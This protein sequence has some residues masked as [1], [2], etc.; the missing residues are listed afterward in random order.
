[1]ATSELVLWSAAL[2]ALFFMGGGPDAATLCVFHAFGF[3]HCPGCGLGNAIH[4]ALHLHWTASFNHH[5]LG[6][7]VLLL[8]LGRV[9]SLLLSR[10]QNHTPWITSN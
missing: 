1:M 10:S 8:L 6:I 9:A 3:I 2:I 7:P 4:E 5:P